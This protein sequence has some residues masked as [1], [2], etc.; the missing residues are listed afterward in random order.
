[1]IKEKNNFWS[2]LIAFSI[3]VYLFFLSRRG[4]NF[5]INYVIYLDLFL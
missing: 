4:Y 2:Q 5:Y 3:L 1:M